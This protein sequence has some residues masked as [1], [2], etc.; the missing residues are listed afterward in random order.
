MPFL[1]AK[2]EATSNTE[3]PFRRP[4]I[5]PLVIFDALD[6][7]DEV[8]LP[9]LLET[10]NQFLVGGPFIHF[11]AACRHHLLDVAEFFQAAKTVPIEA[12]LQDIT[13]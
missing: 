8:G 9:T 12:D 10:V 6:E 11:F 1:E 4:E 7:F 13:D 2:I 3:Q 5:F